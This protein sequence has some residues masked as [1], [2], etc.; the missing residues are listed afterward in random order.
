MELRL[1]VATAQ[2]TALIQQENAELRAKLA[3]AE[4]RSQGFEAGMRF[5]HGDEVG[6]YVLPAGSHSI[7]RAGQSF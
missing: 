6:T 2:A 4:A 1:Q 7:C 5:Q 3:A